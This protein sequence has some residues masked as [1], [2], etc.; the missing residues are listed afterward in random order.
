MSKAL[1]KTRAIVL[2]T[3]KYRESSVIAELFTEELGLRK[4]IIH[5]VR[6][7]KARVQ[8]ALLQVMALVDI[9]AYEREDRDLLHLAEIKAGYAY[10]ELPF[11]IRKG[12]VSLFMAEV[13]QKTIRESSP[14][15]A[16]FA[17]LW[18][19]MEMLDTYQ[20]K[21]THWPLLYLVHLSAQLGFW[22]AGEFD[23]KSASWFDMQEG[24][25][26]E[27][28]PQHAYYMAPSEAQA[29]SQALGMTFAEANEWGITSGL[30]RKVLQATLD[31]YRMH[32]PNMGNIQSHLIFR[33]VL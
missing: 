11:D 15:E 21:M 7:K 25:F 16:L 13:A 24:E 30:R 12:A 14:N 1:I 27:T 28:V 23:E 19:S 22:P 17:F 18:D 31:Y 8:S 3:I 6:Q 29:F 20:G 9:V 10:R 2:R 4:Y 32:I 26:V 5:G 33:E